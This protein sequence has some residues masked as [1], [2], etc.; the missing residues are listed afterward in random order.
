MAIKVVPLPGK[1]GVEIQGLNLAE[2]L[3]PDNFKVWRQAFLQHGLVVF[4]G[5]TLSNLEHVD[6]SLNFG[7]LEVFPDPKDQAEGFGTI[8]R[9]TN[10]DKM[11]NDIRS[12]DED[13]GFKSFVLGTG[14]WH[15]DSSFRKN[16]G[17]ASLLYAK[18]I[19]LFEGDTVFANTN[20]AFEAM[21]EERKTYL[22]E[23]TV[24]HDFNS[25]RRRFGL[26]DRPKSVSDKTPPVTHSLV[27]E[28]PDGKKV[29]MIGIH[30]LQIDGMPKSESDDLLE[31][32]KQWCIQPRFVH[33]HKWHVG[34]V[35]MWDNR[36]IMHRAMPYDLENQRRLLHRTTIDA[37]ST[38]I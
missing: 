6:I 19:P 33:H 15:I 22:S 36:S 9:V 3:S 21:A 5:Q 8:L 1:M 2:P 25:T 10:V 28:L 32:L 27:T 20:F 38:A 18:E 4:Q 7:P 17:K 26:P 31:E 30:A 14:D 35:V 11:T 24:V 12:Y 34:D 23:L 16:P 13:V 29:L 37:V